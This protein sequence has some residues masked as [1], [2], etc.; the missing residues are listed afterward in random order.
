MKK[1]LA[2]LFIGLT[3]NSCK[4]RKI[5]N[6]IDGL[7]SIDTIYFKNYNIRTCLA[8]NVLYFKLGGQSELPIARNYCDS[9]IKK[10][11]DRFA[12]IE[13]VNSENKSDT[14]PL[15]LKIISNNEIFAG[16]QKI[17]FY[18][19]QPNHLL[20]MEIFSSKLYIV[21]RKGLFNYDQNISLMNNLEEKSWTNRPKN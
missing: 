11:F 18:K 3:L 10:S 12:T 14:I 19:D 4:D 2:I 5:E 7:W 1:I 8:N 6:A 13:L 21:C 20:K 9:I 15:R 17:I 16:I